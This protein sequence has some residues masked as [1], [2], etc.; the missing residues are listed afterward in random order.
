M[1]EDDMSAENI[2]A[3]SM[4]ESSW[5]QRSHRSWT[6]LISFAVQAVAMAC[7]LMLPM[8]RTVGLP[9]GHS[10]PTPVTWG[11]PP[12]IRMVARRQ[13]ANTA[14]SNLAN[15]VLIAPR[16]IPRA[17]QMIQE[18]AAPPQ[19]DFS[20]FGVHGETGDSSRN[21]V[22]RSIGDSL[23]RMVLPLSP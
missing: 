17:V 3:E 18:V 8:M 11:P 7:L 15:D 20:D 12:E 19:V 5:S 4:L 9:S 21:G 14:L 23:N 10:L 1:Q 2:F 16:E 6:T 22:W 13:S